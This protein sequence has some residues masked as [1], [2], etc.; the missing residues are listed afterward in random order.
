MVFVL[1]RHQKPLM[2][3]SEKRARLLL[4]RGRAVVH[5]MAPFTIRLKNRE[6]ASSARQPLRLKLDPG[7]KTT[8]VA[9]LL[10]GAQGA[11]GVL[12]GEIV[13]KT[14][15]KARLDARRALR[16]GRRYRKTRYR[17]PR[18]NNRQRKAGWLPPSLAAR[19]NQTLH[20][21]TKLR[22]LT[23]LTQ[24]SVEHVKFDTQALENPEIRGAEYQQGTLL[25]YEVREYLL[26]KWGRAC[27]YCGA[28]DV[29]LEVEHIVPKSRGGTSRV[30]NLALAC[31]ACNQTKGT[32]TAMEFGYP[33]IHAQARRPLKDAAM[34]NA[35]RWRLYAQLTATGLPVEGGS[36]GRTKMQRIAHDLPKEHYYDAL[37]VGESTPERFSALPVYIHV[38]GAKGRGTRQLAGL[39]RAGFPTRHRS[40]GRRHMGFQTG[41]LI[42]GTVVRGPYAGTWM[43][44]VTVRS[45][46]RFVLTTAAGT[47]IEVPA[48]AC[49]LIQRQDG[50]TY[51]VTLIG[52]G[53]AASPPA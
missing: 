46:P 27:V 9:I 41:D 28:T 4:E 18:F 32:Q 14:G 19:V 44:R 24:V 49:S 20:A 35:T 48:R 10:T 25:G 33:Q 40:R 38:W 13:H 6:K 39:N 12:L 31:H 1:D 5:R 37:C 53:E 42:R 23:P 45:R 26:E 16:R 36:G 17:K 29:P 51:H 22:Q 3:C 47:R 50:W 15:I 7:S 43:G 52:A 8:G 34:M 11:K 30:S 21:V 2:P